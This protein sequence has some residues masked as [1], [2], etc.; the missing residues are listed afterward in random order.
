MQIDKP[1]ALEQTPRG[2]NNEAPNF[3]GPSSDANFFAFQLDKPTRLTE[4]PV[5]VNHSNLLAQASAQL[6]KSTD[7]MSKSLRAFSKNSSDDA[8][9]KYPAQLSNTLLMSH[10][11]VKSLGKTAQCVEKIGNLQ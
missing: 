9:R 3:P 5:P 10:V 2:I 7:Q 11:L 1:F 6:Q 4:T 8:M